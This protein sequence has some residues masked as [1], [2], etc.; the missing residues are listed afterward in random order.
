MIR[1]SPTETLRK[2]SYQER[3]FDRRGMGS[4]IGKLK[5]GPYIHRFLSMPSGVCSE[6]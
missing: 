5:T 6:Y 2:D 4:Q 3:K 1:M